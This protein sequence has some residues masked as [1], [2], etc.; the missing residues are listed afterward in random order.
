MT[1][2]EKTEAVETATA[3]VALSPEQQALLAIIIRTPDVDDRELHRAGVPVPVIHKFMKQPPRSVL[4]KVNYATERDRFSNVKMVSFESPDEL[5]AWF[6]DNPGH[7]LLDWKTDSDYILALIA[8]ILTPSEQVELEV[9]AN[10]LAEMRQKRIEEKEAAE[11]EAEAARLAGERE[12]AEL[13]EAGRKCREHHAPLIKEKRA[14][15]K[16]K[17][18]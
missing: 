14:E 2:T 15:K 16:G 6:A 9:D 17:K 18:R 4:G 12:R 10:L 5:N 1:E 3:P 7:L 8:R 13:I 11:W